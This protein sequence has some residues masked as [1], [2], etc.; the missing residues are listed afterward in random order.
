[1]FRVSL[2]SLRTRRT[3]HSQWLSLLSRLIVDKDVT[4]VHVT[5]TQTRRKYDQ[6]IT[7]RHW[8]SAFQQDHRLVLVI[9]L[10]T[11]S[12]IHLYINTLFHRLRST[13][14]SQQCN[15]QK[16]R[17]LRQS[18]QWVMG[19]RSLGQTGHGSDGSVGHGSSES[20]GQMGQWVQ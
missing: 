13:T 17:W 15:K 5:I 12:N 8:L 6:T 14:S 16:Y 20:M 19:H 4:W 11:I 18:D 9:T 1:M 2:Y 7:D 10:H 3:I